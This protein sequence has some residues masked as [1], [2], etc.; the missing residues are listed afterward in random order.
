[1]AARRVAPLVEGWGVMPAGSCGEAAGFDGV[2]RGS[3]AWPVAMWDDAGGT[4]SAAASRASK[5]LVTLAELPGARGA[6][7][8]ASWASAEEVRVRLSDPDTTICRASESDGNTGE[9]G[10]PC[11]CSAGAALSP[12]HALPTF[13]CETAPVGGTAVLRSLLA[14]RL[15][16]LFVPN[17]LTFSGLA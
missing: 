1:M 6:T 16:V 8:A 7:K 13:K 15:S 10:L 9:R 14:L 12:R 5:A 3:A 17:A 11:G 4:A 2:A